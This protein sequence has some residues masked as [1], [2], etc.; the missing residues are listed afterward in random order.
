MGVSDFNQTHACPK[1]THTDHAIT[2]HL[3]S[4]KLWYGQVRRPVLYCP[5]CSCRQP[6]V[7]P[8]WLYWKW[9]HRKDLPT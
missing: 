9:K 7:L 8:G 4:F 6:L 2:D 1:C 5:Q 3:E